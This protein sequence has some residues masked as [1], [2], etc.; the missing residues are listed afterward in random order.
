MKAIL[1]TYNQAYYDEIAKGNPFFAQ[2]WKPLH[3][4]NEHNQYGEEVFEGWE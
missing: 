2:I 1:I 4:E 3:G